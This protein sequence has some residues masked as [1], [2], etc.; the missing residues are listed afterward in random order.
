MVYI[1]DI[2]DKDVVL[3]IS[4]KIKSINI[5]GIIGAEYVSRFVCEHAG[6]I[7][8]QSGMTEKP[9]IVSAKILEGRVA[10]FIDGTPVVITYP[11]DFP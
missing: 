1:D 5:D 11:Y 4:E 8:N 9:D 6:S 7:F 2:V 10:L 3:R